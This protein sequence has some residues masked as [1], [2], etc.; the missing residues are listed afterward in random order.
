MIEKFRSAVAGSD[1]VF[2]VGTGLSASATDN[3]P[4]A[5]WI[6]LIESGIERVCSISDAEK[7]RWRDL[8]SGLLE[9]GREGGGSALFIQAAGMV[10]NELKSV[11]DH[12]YARWLEES[13]G[14][15]TVKHPGPIRALL[16][17]PFP[18]LTTN[19]DTLLEQVGKRASANWKDE[20]QFHEV[21]TRK[22]DAIA[23]IH[24]VWNRP[25]SVVLSEGDYAHLLEHRST[26]ALEQAMSALKSIVYVGFGSGLSDPNFSK[27][28]NW[29]RTVLPQSS[30]VHFRLCLASEEADLRRRHGDDNVL[31]V[32]Y[33]SEYKD[34]ERF[35]RAES[36][37]RE[38]LTINEAGLA[39][40]AV[41]EARDDLFESMSAE[42][43]LLEAG[44]EKASLPRLIVPPSLLPM[45]HAMYVRERMRQ[46]N[47][48]E[49]AP[50]DP[51]LEVES[52]DLM[53]VVGDDGSGVTTTVK[54]L[55]HEASKL[56]GTAAPIYVNFRHCNGK[57]PLTSAVTSAAMSL[58]LMPA[59]R[60]SIP[61]HVLA[62]DDYDPSARVIGLSVLDEFVQSSAIVRIIGC[63]Q[64]NEEIVMTR[65]RSA[66]LNP[67][68]QYLGRMRSSDV[69]ALATV[70]SP[71]E[72]QRIATEVSRV[73]K[74][75]GLNRTP[76]TVS[77]LIYLVHR[78]VAD[79]SSQT[80]IIDSY[81]HL[82]L[83]IGDPH[84]KRPSLSEG[85]L[86]A[87]LANLAAYMTWEERSS[88]PEPEAI[89]VVA[90]AIARYSWPAQATEVL[91]YLQARRILRVDRGNVEFMRTS[92]FYIFAAKRA[93]ADSDFR[94]LIG[95]DPFYY[96]PVA[97]RYAA[98]VKTDAEFLEQMIPV[99]QASL[100]EP[101]TAATPYEVLPTIQVHEVPEDEALDVPSTDAEVELTS[102]QSTPN[103][104]DSSAHKVVRRH[105]AAEL[106]MP[107]YN[108]N[109]SFG[110]KRE[111]MSVAARLSRSVRLVSTVL[112]DMD[113]AETLDTKKR[114]LVDTLELW[115]RYVT[116]LDADE[117]T[118][119]FRETLSR[120]MATI[121]GDQAKLQKAAEYL[122]KGFPAST[123]LGEMSHTLVSSKL[124]PTFHRAMIEGALVETEERRTASLFFL[125]ALRPSGWAR[126]ALRLLDG[127]AATWV[128]SN[129][130]HDH[131]WSEYIRGQD[132]D[133]DLM[134]L[135]QTLE[136]LEKTFSNAKARGAHL[137]RYERSLRL[138][139]AKYLARKG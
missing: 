3:A 19:Y 94:E 131:C 20:I 79:S 69:R 95:N 47:D 109:V 127:A 70:I 58:G 129:F 21:L 55:A 122:S 26:V 41:Q 96:E 98:L 114:L 124:L 29:H 85:D 108:G 123:A 80:S 1:V 128:L 139:R 45:P 126:T 37:A 88:L 115:G 30:A 65:L 17:Y 133:V 77:I 44:V 46:T 137:S 10:S 120:Y 112:R 134:H 130:V 48:T 135:C 15:L 76:L 8:V 86:G 33:G 100:T 27:L 56:L 73:L 82:L 31:P 42:S 18:I 105:E 89:D 16:S 75:E 60:S 43:V 99:V 113:Q 39:R 117:S 13:V 107:E 36:P 93:T 24:G 111:E 68:V 57:K 71:T 64:G 118:D 4:T 40:D 104:S 92:Y 50:Y 63:K 101:V 84:L 116:A 5:T 14:T 90:R 138:A 34:L 74:V 2:V 23:H 52:H 119:V 91:A 81:V 83:V 51:Y 62:L 66:G 59:R 78:G 136:V 67:R 54:W 97:T 87:I 35:L 38:A 125:I 121:S 32:V 25:D 61:A 102:P 72:G 103:E 6:G 110:L 22:T 11:G 106:E 7:S 49:M 132:E 9:Y 53:V 28:F 12:E